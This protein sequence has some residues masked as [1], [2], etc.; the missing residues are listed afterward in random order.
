VLSYREAFH[1]KRQIDP[2]QSLS[3]PII[4]LYMA[5]H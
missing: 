5:S 1:Y 4:P 2:R 3:T